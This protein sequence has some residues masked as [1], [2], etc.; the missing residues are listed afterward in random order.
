MNLF[1]LL[2]AKKL[3][4]GGGGITPSGTIEISE[5]GQYDVTQYAEANVNVQS[6]PSE[7]LLWSNPSPEQETIG[8]RFGGVTLDVL[9]Q[10][11]FLKIEW[12]SDISADNTEGIFT[13]YWDMKG[14]VYQGTEI[15]N[16]LVAIGGTSY[17]RSF[18]WGY[19]PSGYLYGFSRAY[20]LGASTANNTKV[21][22]LRVYGIK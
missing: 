3:G 10:Y 1:D 8:V 20:I 14:I 16:G 22:P 2:L 12:K 7:V 6:S 17:C 15:G 9:S 11:R 13:G 21:I 19:T 18:G 5:N 4:G